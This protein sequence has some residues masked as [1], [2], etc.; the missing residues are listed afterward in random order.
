MNY[1]L[2]NKALPILTG[3]MKKMFGEETPQELAKEMMEGA[4]SGILNH[5]EWKIDTLK[6]EK[7][8]LIEEKNDLENQLESIK[9]DLIKAE[10]EL[11]KYKKKK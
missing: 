8:K 10:E 11:V 5:F 1:A 9:R 2:I 6:R 4:V 3:G 7:E